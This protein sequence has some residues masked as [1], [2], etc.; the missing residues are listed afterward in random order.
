MCAVA[1]WIHPVFHPTGAVLTG[2]LAAYAALVAVR[3]AVGGRRRLERLGRLRDQMPGLLARRYVLGAAL[4]LA[5]CGV[6]VLVPVVD[7]GVS[8]V[9]LGLTSPAT[10]GLFLCVGYLV[11][12]GVGLA[13][14]VSRDVRR[15][16]DGGPVRAERLLRR[17]A[18]LKPSTARERWL[19]AGLALAAGVGEEVVFRGLF[20]AAGV[21][22]LHLSIV[23]AAGAT[24]VVFG[25]V[26][27][28]QG[29]RGAVNATVLGVLFTVVYL[30]SGTLWVPIV[31]HQLWDLVALLLM[32][33]L[34]APRR[35][36][37]VDGDGGPPPQRDADGARPDSVPT[38]RPAVEP[39][40]V[41]RPAAP[42][43]E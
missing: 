6:A 17:M 37:P 20:V 8:Y 29:V 15:S 13:V 41:V 11:L 31:V 10:P 33:R 42:R 26:H 34:M 24:A 18:P 28:Y 39:G 14:R 5:A 22:L 38:T 30:W 19:A 21:G 36:P 23:Y 43:G 2:L 3:G 35:E 27:L 25:L 40:F 9:D 12:V 1:T 32:P 4:T 7:P 16:R